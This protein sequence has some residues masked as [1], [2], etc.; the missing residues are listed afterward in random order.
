MFRRSLHMWCVLSSPCDHSMNPHNSPAIGDAEACCGENSPSAF[1]SY[2]FDGVRGQLAKQ[3]RK[4]K[5]NGLAR[6][7]QHRDSH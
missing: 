1:F 7:E 4:V 5:A 6:E 2:K 3:S